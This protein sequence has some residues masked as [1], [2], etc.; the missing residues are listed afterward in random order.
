[1]RWLVE[2]GIPCY[3]A[4]DLAVNA[5]AA[6]REFYKLRKM[7]NDSAYPCS[8]TGGTVARKIIAQARKDGRSALTEVESKLVFAAYDLPI[9][10][11]QLAKTEEEAVA[12]GEEDRLPPC[13]KDRFTSNSA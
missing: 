6:L 8:S 9:A 1:M 7:V 10:A 5:M 11:T 3:N 4:P 13:I 12:I 2:N